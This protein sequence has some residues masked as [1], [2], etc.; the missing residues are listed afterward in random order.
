MFII[1]KSILNKVF[2][3]CIYFKIFHV[4]FYKYQSSLK[5]IKNLLF[6]VLIYFSVIFFSS[7]IPA[8]SDP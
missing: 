4:L 1:R 5:K 6:I 7:M 3:V 2:K 8:K